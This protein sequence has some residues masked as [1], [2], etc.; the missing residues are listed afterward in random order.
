MAQRRDDLAVESEVSHPV[1]ASVQI[2]ADEVVALKNK[3]LGLRAISLHLSRI[4]TVIS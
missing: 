3:D 1:P 2:L 4:S